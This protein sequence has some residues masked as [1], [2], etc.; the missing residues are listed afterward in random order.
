MAIC[1]G[2]DKEK[3]D[4]RTRNIPIR[5]AGQQPVKG[6]SMQA[7]L[8]D[9]CNSAIGTMSREKLEEIRRKQ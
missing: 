9:S 8:C 1:K 4:V 3:P 7:A 5:E 6:Q 2:C